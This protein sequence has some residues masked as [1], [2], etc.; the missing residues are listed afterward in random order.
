M[1]DRAP[2]EL[3]SLASVMQDSSFCGLGQS[4]AIPMNSALTH[5]AADFARAE[6]EQS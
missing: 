3:K 6:K 2:E 1:T 5:F 4:V